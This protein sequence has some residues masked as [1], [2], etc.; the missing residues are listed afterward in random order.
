MSHEPA[1]KV[2]G[3]PNQLYTRD[4]RG[5]LICAVCFGWFIHVMNPDEFKQLGDK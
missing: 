2:C 4:P 3:R 1:C 5:Y